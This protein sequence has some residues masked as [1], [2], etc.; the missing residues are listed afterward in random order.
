MADMREEL[1]DEALDSMLTEDDDETA[2]N[3][4]IGQ[5]LDE[6][7]IETKQTVNIFAND[8][9]NQWWGPVMCHSAYSTFID[10]TKPNRTPLPL[11]HFKF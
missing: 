4:I 7:G 8:Y 3:R 2:E 6:L 11:P 5:V 9:H 10:E 1:I